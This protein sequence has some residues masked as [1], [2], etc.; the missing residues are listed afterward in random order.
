MHSIEQLD[1]YFMKAIL[2]WVSSRLFSNLDKK[3]GLF[4][5]EKLL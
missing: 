4:V 5:D 3:L 2:Y 1:R